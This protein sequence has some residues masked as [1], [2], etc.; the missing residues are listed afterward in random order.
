MPLRVANS[1]EKNVVSVPIK[2]I[3]VPTTTATDVLDS[4][5]GHRAEYAGRYIQN[6][7][8]NACY[9]AIGHDCDPTNF[10][11]ILSQGAEVD[12]NGFASGM[13]FDAS[14]NGQRVSVYSVGGTTISVTLL[15]RNDNEQG[16]G[17]IIPNI[18]QG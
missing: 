16:N 13:Q 11:G 5:I 2:P 8:A 4:I 6:V 3:V 7:G 14:N 10:N 15:K 18:C 17:N 12:A 9:Y 1:V